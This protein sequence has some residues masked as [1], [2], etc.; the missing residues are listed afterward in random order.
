MN[1][2]I[3]IG[4]IKFFRDFDKLQK[5][6]DGLFYC[7][8]PEFYRQSDQKGVSDLH[9]SCSHSYRKNR[10][11]DPIKIKWGDI[12][13]DGL[14]A[15]TIHTNG[16]KDKWLHC[17]FALDLPETPEELVTL[18]NNINSMRNEF[19][20]NFA[21]IPNKS[22]SSLIS[23]LESSTTHKLDHGLVKYSTDKMSWSYGCKSSSYSYQKEYRIV[24]GEC[25]HTEITHLE[26]Q[27]SEDFNDLI[28]ANGPLQITDDK[29]GDVWFHLDKNQCYC[30]PTA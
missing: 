1:T 6:R 20:E 13:F 27:S 16:T 9:E 23:K 8:T 30:N 24:F 18:V 25:S 2:P 12:E 5:L 4:L 22:F 10:D 15:A 29:T 26:I 28:W 19:G 11:D 14:T 3:R 21:F 17:W 7:N